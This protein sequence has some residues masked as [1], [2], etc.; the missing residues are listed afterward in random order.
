MR[1]AVYTDQAYWRHEGAVYASRAFI[2]FIGQLAESFERTVVIGRLDPEPARS[3]YKLAD[4]LEFEPLPF[5]SDAASPLSALRALGRA[6]PTFWRVLGRVDAVWV[7][8]PYPLSLVLV[9]LA[10]LRRKRV[11]LGVRQDTPRY[12]RNRRPGKRLLHAAVDALEGA[13]RLLARRFPIVVVGPQLA[14]NYARARQPLEVSVSLVRDRDVVAAGELERTWNGAITVVSVGRLDPEKNPLMLADVLARLRSRDTRWR[15]V[16][17]GDGPLEGELRARLTELGVSEHAVLKGHVPIDQGLLDVYRSGH[18]FLHVSWTEGL[19]QVLLEAMA[20][21]MPVIATDVGGVAQ[22]VDGA[23]LLVPPGDVEAAAGALESV[24]SD[25]PL[26]E[27]LVEAGRAH[28]RRY[29]M[30]AE[31]RR[32]AEFISGRRRDGSQIQRTGSQ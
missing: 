9:A 1:V 10:A 16:V 32:V 4:R 26:R 7:L 31:C 2:V 19:P 18:A 17:C 25:E 20:A 15:L 6:V 28:V 3:H 30:E 21:A 22:A 5:Y 14:R 27:K 12:I 8:G 24:A 11:V 23:A 13:F 29:T